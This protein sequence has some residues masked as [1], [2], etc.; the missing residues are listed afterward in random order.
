MACVYNPRT[1]EAEDREFSHSLVYGNFEAFLGYMRFC[2]R[3]K[4]KNCATGLRRSFN[5]KALIAPTCEPEFGNHIKV[6][7]VEQKPVIPGLRRWVHGIPRTSLLAK[8]AK[9]G[10]LQVQGETLPQ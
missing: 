6:R 8:I 2:L 7:Q 4:K 1:L 5:E 3:K 10:K 9:T